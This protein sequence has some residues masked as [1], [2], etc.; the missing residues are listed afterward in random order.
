MKPVCGSRICAPL[1]LALLIVTCAAWADGLNNNEVE[2]TGAISSLVVNGEG[3]GT[4]FIRLND[5]DLRVV[6]ND[7][8]EILSSDLKPIV[9]ADLKEDDRVTITGKYSASGVLASKI[10]LTGSESADFNLRGTINKVETTAGVTKLT[11]LGIQVIVNTDTQITD[12][13]ATLTPSSLTT[14]LKVEIEGSVGTDGWVA[15]TITILSADHRNEQ[16]RFEGK[17]L[18]LT[19]DSLKVEAAG[20]PENVTTVLLDAKTRILGEL[21]VGAAV[22]VKGTLNSDL[23]VSAREIRVLQAF[24]VKPDSKKLKVGESATFIV[25]LRESADADVVFTL[26]SG[27]ETIAKLNV[28]SLTIPKGS[29]TAE[30]VVTGGP[31]TGSTEITVEALGQTA[32]VRIKV[33][34]VSEEENEKKAGQTSIVFAPEQIKLGLNETRDVV[35]LIR[36]PQKSAVAVVLTI[37]GGIVKATLGS[38]LGLG[39]AAYKVTVQSTD[40]T[41]SDSVVAALPE[42][43]GGGTA[44]LLVVVSATPDTP[45]KSKATIDFSTRLVKLAIDESLDVTL[46]S[47]LS[48]D[49]DVTIALAVTKGTGVIQTAQSITLAAGTKSVKISVKGIAAGNAILTAAMPAEQGGDTADL[50]VQVKKK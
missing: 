6:V 12:D 10:I 1:V 11:L 20:L 26:K 29:T 37:P 2:F 22:Y 16:V 40:K 8:T 15:K 39:A 9:M 35:L 45:K 7:T 31:N 32:T 30:F 17:I 3:V 23:S 48:Y 44:E 25:K 50:N 36:P 14:G 19:N 46:F 18:S 41:G 13:T 21:S 43:L 42:E 24:E 4:L 33:G 27:D 28:S 38:L 34:L 47:S 5:F 49:K